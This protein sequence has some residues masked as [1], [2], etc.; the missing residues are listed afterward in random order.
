MRP[1]F[2]SIICGKER[3]IMMRAASLLEEA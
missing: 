1:R 2:V 3:K